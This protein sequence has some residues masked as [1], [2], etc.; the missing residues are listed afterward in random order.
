MVT[1]TYVCPHCEQAEAVVRFGFTENGSQRLR[2]QACR[3]TWSPEGKSRKLSA[4]KQGLI[5]KAL[6]ERTSQRGIARALNAS[7]DTIRAVQKKRL[8]CA[9]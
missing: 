5:E 8:A 6:G 7:R 2:C 1:K 3:K 9:S 4:E